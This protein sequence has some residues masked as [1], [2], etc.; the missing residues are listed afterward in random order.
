M[1]LNWKLRLQNRATLAAL[2][3]GVVG[4]VYLLLETA[5]IVPCVT[6]SE[7]TALIAG[8]LNLL[9]LLGVLVD[10]TTQGVR[11]SEK[12]LRYDCPACPH[13]DAPGR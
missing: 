7:V 4:L 2:L 13:T 10:P 6:Q 11:D 1:R 3:A 9:V 12:A 5:G 8:V